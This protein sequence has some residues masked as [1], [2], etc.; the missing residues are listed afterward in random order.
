MAFFNAALKSTL[1][2]SEGVDEGAMVGA[3]VG[4]L[5]GLLVGFFLGFEATVGALVRLGGGTQSSSS[6]GHNLQ[7][8]SKKTISSTPKENGVVRPLSVDDIVIVH[9][10]QVHQ[11]KVFKVDGLRGGKLNARFETLNRKETL[12]EVAHSSF[13]LFS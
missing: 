12:L 13:R 11:D 5:V 1:G 7:V 10:V 4:A 6:S 9:L 3:L 8:Y 2:A